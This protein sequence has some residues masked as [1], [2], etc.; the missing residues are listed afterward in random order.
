MDTEIRTTGNLLLRTISAEALS[1]VMAVAERHTIEIRDDVILPNQPIEFV[2]FPEEGVISIVIKMNEKDILE[3]ATVGH[4]GMV[5]SAL[6]AGVATMPEWAFCQVRARVLRIKTDDFFALILKH[7]DF[8][9]LCKRYSATIFNQV[10]RNMGCLWAH[11]IEERCARW[12]LHTHDRVKG[13][14]FY[15]TQEFLAMMLGVTRGGVN[16]VAG[17]FQKAGFIDYSRGR[18]IILDR[19]G[20]E[21]VTCSCYGE[22]TEYFR[23]NISDFPTKNDLELN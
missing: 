7:P 5:G 22:I 9:A 17:G 16:L 10:A 23:K 13:N 8:A 4:E 12:L 11:N 1:D 2:D 14:E 21:S 20:L 15:L 3:V 6:L 18:L 19:A